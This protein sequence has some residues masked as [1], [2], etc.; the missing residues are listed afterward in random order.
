MKAISNKKGGGLGFRKWFIFILIGLAGQFAWSI[1]NMYLNTY[2]T[3][4]NFTAPVAEKFNYSLMIAVT[5]A[6]SAIVAA[7]ATIFM[8]G[9]MDKIQKRKIFISIG[10]IVWGVATAS[11]G[12]LNVGSSMDLIPIAMTASTAAIMVIVID[13]IMTYFGST[14]NDAAFMSYVTKNTDDKNRGKVEGVMSILPL[15]SMLIIFVGLNG[16]TT[17]ENGY[18][19]DLF[20]YIV[21]GA[22]LLVGLISIVLIPKE[23]VVAKE[24]EPYFRIVVEGFKPSTIR[25]NKLLY[26]LL[27]AYFVYGVAC[28]IYFPYLMVYVERTC[29]ISNSSGGFLTPFAIVMAIALLFGSLGSVLIGFLS[30][31]VGKFKM[32][33]PSILIMAIGLVMLFFAPRIQNDNARI[34]YGA[35][36]GFVM[37][38]GY[39]AIPTVVNSLVREYIPKGK[40]GSFMGVRMVFVVA[41]P[42]CIGP[43]IGD[44]LNQAY[45]KPY[46]D[47]FGSLAHTPSEYGYIV[48]LVALLLMIIPIIFVLKENKKHAK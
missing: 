11:F 37:I 24:N 29:N 47:Q 39:V 26:L 30:D 21:G 6:L 34:A 31:K 35:I 8:G 20:F 1:E 27:I 10:Y 44:A 43:F 7:F 5:T 33:I 32:I 23:D 36:S 19:W 18:R 2:I 12:L 22:V 38:L 40:E 15:I 17:Q 14:S 28:N 45:G 25:Q 4:L 48:A 9:L 42:M 46:N 3:Y 16:L 41:L 13:C